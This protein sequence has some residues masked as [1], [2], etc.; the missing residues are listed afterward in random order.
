MRKESDLHGKN[1]FVSVSKNL[2]RYR[3][4]KYFIDHQNNCSGSILRIM[5]QKVL[6]FN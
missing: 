2:A 4:R 3:S 5:L 6:T 1:S